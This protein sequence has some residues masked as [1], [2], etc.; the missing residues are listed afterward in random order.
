MDYKKIFIKNACPTSIGGQAIMEGVMMRGPDRT[1]IAMRLPS[2]E[3]FLKTEKRKKPGVFHKIPVIRGAVSFFESLAIGIG[4]L[5]ESADVLEQYLPEDEIE[6]PGAL[7]QK[8]NNRFGEKAAWNIMLTISLIISLVIA[9]GVFV[10]FPTVATN[11]LKHWVQSHVAL[12]LIEGGFRILLFVLYIVLISRMKEIQTLFQYHGAE[13]KTIHCFEN[14]LELTPANAAQFYRLHPRCG[15]SFLMFVMIISLL[16]FSFLGWPNLWLRIGSRILLMPVIAGLSYEV[17][18]WAGRSDNIVVRVLS[19]PGLML[20]LLT[21]RD[22]DEHQLEIAIVSLKA[23]LVD[24]SAPVIDGIVDTN[25]HLLPE[26]EDVIVKTDGAVSTSDA[27]ESEIGAADTSDTDD[28]IKSAGADHTDRSDTEG[29]KAQ[30]KCPDEKQDAE[31]AESLEESDSTEKPDSENPASGAGPSFDGD[32]CTVGNLIRWGQSELSDI[33]NGR[34]EAVDIFSYTMG[35]SR[36]D[37]IL[38]AAD[39]VVD[40]DRME[41]EERIGRRLSG[42]PLQYIVGV[43]E[44]MGLLFRVN[45]NVLIPRLDT[46]V[47][48]DQAIRMLKEKN[49]EDPFILDICTGS[50]AIGITVAHEIPDAEVTLADISTEAVSTAMGNAQINEVFRRCIFVTGNMFEA[51]PEHK[52]YDMILCNPPYIE[53][54][55]IETL[56]E[57]V[58]DHEPRLALDGGEDGL[59]FYRILAR[60]AEKHLADG[61]ILIMEIGYNQGEA[62]KKLLEENGNYGPVTVMK[63]LNHLDRVVYTERKER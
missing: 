34:N 44:F 39:P 37:M 25:A 42:T 38:R 41:Y 54:D 5:M 2:D 26:D 16:L 46:E 22:P 48:A 11:W 61:G 50:G 35:F 55:V 27:S 3:I 49:W 4:T 33:E 7:E 47:L 6:E 17:L 62:V 15:T 57:E 21:T 45:P 60:D 12:N 10:V 1:A 40:S 29:T 30:D 18:R 20:Q 14:E 58:K 8:I 32:K 52:R 9:V 53:S 28:I 56:S 13:H 63:D 23:V 36:T 43:Q 51:V 31:T 19:Y 24:K 59:V